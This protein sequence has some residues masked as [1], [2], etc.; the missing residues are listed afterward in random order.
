MDVSVK[1]IETVAFP[2]IMSIAKSV[3]GGGTYPMPELGW[4]IRV[5]PPQ[6][7]TTTIT[8][9]D[10]YRSAEENR[11]FPFKTASQF[12]KNH[13]FIMMLPYSTN[14]NRSLPLNFAGSTEIFF[15]AL[16]RRAFMQLS[17]DATDIRNFDEQVPPG[18]K[19]SDAAS[20]LS[21]ILF[22]NL[23][24]PNEAWLYTNPRA[25]HRLSEYHLEQMFDFH[26]P[27]YLG[28]D[29]FSYDNY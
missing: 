19:V 23:D 25:K 15:R 26:I 7:L 18:V 2:K 27:N 11:Y 29:D 16:A 4:T 12:A 8:A 22:L 17:S 24:K 9:F 28:I 14:F 13:P 20:L 3:A 5:E 1:E 6:R 21:G 10:A